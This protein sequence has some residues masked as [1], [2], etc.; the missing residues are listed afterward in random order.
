MSLPTPYEDLLRLVLEEGTPKADRT[1][2]GTR[3]V[4]GH[5]LRYRL[6]DGF[7]LITT[8]RV[9]LKSVIYE[10]LWFLRGE[11]NVRWLQERGV[12]I[13]DEWAS[14]AG[15]LGPVYG[16]QWRAWPT[17]SGEHIDQISA[18][19]DLLRTNPDSRRNIV[20]AWNV[21]EIPQMALPPCHAFFQFYVADGKL[22]CQLY[23]RSAD[24][25]L[26]VPFNI[27]SYALLTH[28]MAAQAGLG[29]GDFVWTGGDCHI[30]DNHVEQVTE[31]LSRDPYPYP[32]L[33]LAQRDSIFDYRYEDITVENYQHHAA[34]KAPVAV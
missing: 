22:S 6:E 17:P 4:F 1:G 31:Q 9:H 29:V 5:Q 14:E 28:M 32:T 30:Y 19:L 33:V 11:S 34:I 20:S 23:Q 8:K 10:L 2:T 21:G 25:F 16:V 27:A 26:G 3:S 24:L 18:A 15:E 12:T 13:W 7:P